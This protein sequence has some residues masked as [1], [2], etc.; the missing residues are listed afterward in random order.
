MHTLKRTMTAVGL[1]TI[2][3]MTFTSGGYAQDRGRGGGQEVGGGDETRDEIMA[4]WR[5][6]IEY[7]DRFSDQFPTVSARALRRRMSG[8]FRPQIIETRQD[9]DGITNA[10]ACFYR[11]PR[12][13]LDVNRLRW[14][15]LSS[16][17]KIRIGTHE[18]LRTEDLD[19]DYSLTD[20][21]LGMVPASSFMNL[22]PEQCPESI[23][24]CTFHREIRQPGATDM[25][26]YI[27]RGQSVTLSIAGT[28]QVV[29]GGAVHIYYFN[30]GSYACSVGF[31]VAIGRDFIEPGSDFFDVYAGGAQSIDHLFEGGPGHL[32]LALDEN[33]LCEN[34]ER[35]QNINGEVT[36]QVIN[37]TAGL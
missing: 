32:V 22:L 19:D 14:A 12:L 18:L 3:A 23:P 5:R 2:L 6:A 31:A 17:E 10:P 20:M 30:G 34:G 9:C 13:R 1:L 8:G 24:R 21:L 29:W 36:I 35:F 4:I 25:N 16:L 37:S 15:A 11:R 27:R 28:F 7:F 33:I 26:L